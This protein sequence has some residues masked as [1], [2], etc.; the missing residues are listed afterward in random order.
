MNEHTRYALSLKGILFYFSYCCLVFAACSSLWRHLTTAF[1]DTYTVESATFANGMIA[2]TTG[3][4]FVAVGVAFSYLLGWIRH[5]R[6]VASWAF[7][8]GVFVF[9]PLFFVSLICLAVL[10]VIDLD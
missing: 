1:N 7:V 6:R 9:W 4:V 5:Y 10:G 8:F 2:L 3:L